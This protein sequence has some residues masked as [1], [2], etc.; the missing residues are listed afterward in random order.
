M[1]VNGGTV[2]DTVANWGGPSA[3]GDSGAVVNVTVPASTPSGDTVY[4][5]GQLRRPRDRDPARPTTGPPPT[6]R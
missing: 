3:C 5:S 2:N 4:L 6:T 1:T